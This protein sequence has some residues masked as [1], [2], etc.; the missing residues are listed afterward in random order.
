MK[1]NVTFAAIVIAS[2]TLVYN[3]TMKQT[4]NVSPEER[5][6]KE[7]LEALSDSEAAGNS[8]YCYSEGVRDITHYHY[9]CGDCSFLDGY[10]GEGTQS[11]C[12]VR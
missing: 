2:A 4:S 1:R 3:F 11:V 7:N 8:V 9:R 10:R 6:E 5:L 12:T